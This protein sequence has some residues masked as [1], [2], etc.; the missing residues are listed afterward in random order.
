LRGDQA[1]AVEFEKRTESEKRGALVTVDEGMV[2]RNGRS[3][4]GGELRDIVDTLIRVAIGG[5]RQSRL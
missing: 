5:P 2:R 3:I 4:S 1:L